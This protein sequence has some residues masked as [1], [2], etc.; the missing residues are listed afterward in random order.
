MLNIPRRVL[1]ARA[2]AWGPRPCRD[3]AGRTAYLHYSG[4]L[5][6]SG[7]FG[8]G[9]MGS[10]L[11]LQH[12][13]SIAGRPYDDF[14]VSLFALPVRVPWPATL[15]TLP[16]REVSV[17]PVGALLEVLPTQKVACCSSECCLRYREGFVLFR[18]RRTPSQQWANAVS[19]E[20]DF[21]LHT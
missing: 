1:T 11:F 13:M 18:P 19:G 10:S 9:L 7:V 3:A 15:P 8:L 16:M 5:F 2:Q 12:I 14:S 6:S 21:L 4:L 20:A 17:R